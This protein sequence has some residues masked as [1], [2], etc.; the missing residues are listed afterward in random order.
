MHRTP[1]SQ[2]IMC[3]QAAS[4]RFWIG[5]YRPRSSV[6][7]G[8][9][10]QYRNRKPRH[11]AQSIQSLRQNHVLHSDSTQLPHEPRLLVPGQ[12]STSELASTRQLR[13]PSGLAITRPGDESSLTE[14]RGIP[15]LCVDSL[16]RWLGCIDPL[17]I[18]QRIGKDSAATALLLRRVDGGHPVTPRTAD[19]ARI[20][21]TWDPDSSHSPLAKFGA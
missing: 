11:H 19:P 17:P 16:E 8:R 7:N 21:A 15:A 20:E 3:F 6:P 1:D 12:K 14:R 13:I 2:R 18:R 5:C 10:H 9:P 4:L